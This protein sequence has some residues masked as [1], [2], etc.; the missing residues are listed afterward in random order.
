M[1]TLYNLSLLLIVP[2]G[3]LTYGEE[4]FF[5]TQENEL[6]RFHSDTCKQDILFKSTKEIVCL[7]MDDSIECSEIKSNI[8]EEYLIRKDGSLILRTEMYPCYFCDNSNILTIKGIDTLNR[9]YVN[10]KMSYM[11]T[12]DEILFFKSNKRLK[13]IKLFSDSYEFSTP[14][15]ISNNIYVG[16]NSYNRNVYF[17]EY[18]DIYDMYLSK[19]DYSSNGMLYECKAIG[20]IK[21]DTSLNIKEF[22]VSN[23]TMYIVSDVA[24]YIGP[25]KPPME[26]YKYRKCGL[27]TK[28][29]IPVVKVYCN[30]NSSLYN[31]FYILLLLL[32]VF[33]LIF[34][35]IWIKVKRSNSAEQNSRDLTLSVA[36]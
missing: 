14:Y 8:T 35:V 33:P 25:I 20:A 10:L 31:L 7:S 19:C 11:D 6:V 32:I 36:K 13:S 1:I 29:W 12:R 28:K 4:F 15:D 2:L 24:I 34:L 30:N 23:D 21:S 3:L 26:L 9:E 17:L 27:N 22:I 16:I 18:G 5:K